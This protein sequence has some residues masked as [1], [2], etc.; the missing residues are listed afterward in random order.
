M[1]K[2]GGR[3][4]VGICLAAL[5]SI[6][7]AAAKPASSTKY[8]YYAIS[9]SSPVVIYQALIARGPNVKGVKAY[10]TTTALSSQSGK[11]VQGSTCRIDGYKVTMNFTI[12]LPKLSNAG[13]L[14]GGA[15]REWE[16]FS[17]FLK[18]HEETHRSIW[19]DCGSEME[20]KVAA[21]HLSSC[22]DLDR[23]TVQLWKQ[24]NAACNKRHERLDTNAQYELLRQP[25][26]RL[27][28]QG[29]TQSR[30]AMA[31]PRKKKR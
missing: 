16:R 6:N 28:M 13:A 14:T 21:L 23:K 29:A 25:F 9:G 12:K 1:H 2:L 30:Q 18:Q 4:A 5:A 27:V 31:V 19:L 17:A 7:G 24:T 3:L 10:A 20:R 8:T 26:V 15:K 22:A 11:L